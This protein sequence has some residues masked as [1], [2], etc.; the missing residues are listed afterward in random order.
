M[1]YNFV[2]AVALF[3]LVIVLSGS[4]IGYIRYN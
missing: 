3:I 1:R 2:L 4:F